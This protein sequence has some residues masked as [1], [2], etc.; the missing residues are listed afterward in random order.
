M[1]EALT[2]LGEAFV[3]SLGITA[4]KY[5]AYIEQ[6]MLEHDTDPTASGWNAAAYEEAG[7]EGSEL[8]SEEEAWA[9][10]YEAVWGERERAWAAEFGEQRDKWTTERVLRERERL[11]ALRGEAERRQQ[12]GEDLLQVRVVPE[13]A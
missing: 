6:A 2:N 3:Y 5:G 12:R 11:Q 13:A 10:R 8:L 9:K 7:V 4:P 1:V